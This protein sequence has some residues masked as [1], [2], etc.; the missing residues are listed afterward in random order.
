MIGAHALIQAGV[1]GVSVP[2]W[3]LLQAGSL[4]SLRLIVV[5]VIGAIT[6][7]IIAVTTHFRQSLGGDNDEEA[8]EIEIAS[9]DRDTYSGHESAIEA[10]LTVSEG[11][12]SSGDVT[13]HISGGHASHGGI[14]HNDQTAID[15]SK[16]CRH[17]GA[18]LRSRHGL[19]WNCG[20]K[21]GSTFSSGTLKAV[22]ERL[23]QQAADEA[24]RVR[25]D[26][27]PREEPVETTL[28]ADDDPYENSPGTT[29]EDIRRQEEPPHWR[30]LLGRLLGWIE[31]WKTHTSTY[32]QSVALVTLVAAAGWA[33]SL[34]YGAARFGVSG[35]IALVGATLVAVS[36]AGFATL[37]F[38][39]PGQRKSIGIGYPSAIN[40]VILPLLVIAYYEPVFSVVWDLSIATANAVLDILAVHQ[41]LASYLVTNYTMTDELY[42]LMWTLLAFPAGW[43]LGL[44]ISS[45]GINRRTVIGW[46]R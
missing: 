33:V 13:A 11:T 20:T 27:Q 15:D 8:G 41:G 40:A 7:L 1:S 10:S 22:N 30:R 24:L 6:I 19:C 39:V 46:L 18:M 2:G 38:L 35:F 23:R 26:E 28:A 12:E 32:A 21:A 45:V 3:Q 25:K 16:Q 37:V 43:I 17:C 34:V 42:I 31:R 36:S 9:S 4:G 5:G 14:Q 29:R 44:T